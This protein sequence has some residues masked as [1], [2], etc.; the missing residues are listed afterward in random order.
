[1]YMHHRLLF[2][3]TASLLTSLSVSAWQAQ[4]PNGRRM[5]VEAV[6]ELTV[7]YVASNAVR[8][9]YAEPGA[10]STLP[11]WL[12]DCTLRGGSSSPRC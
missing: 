7:E 12:K 8:I 10:T 11:D 6:P 9:R 2:T 3:L 5:V 4:S 1:M